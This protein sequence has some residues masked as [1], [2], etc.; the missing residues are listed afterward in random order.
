M[1]TA[2]K[3]IQ[4]LIQIDQQIDKTDGEGLR[5]RWVFGKEL[6][7]RRV[8]KKLPAGLLKKL[9][10]ATGK[11]KTEISY[12]A[13]FAEKY[14]TEQELSNALDNFRS[15]FE[16]TQ[17]LSGKL[18]TEPERKKLPRIMFRK[19]PN[20]HCVEECRSALQKSIRVGDEDLAMYC[21]AEICL[22]EGGED[23]SGYTLAWNAL[24]TTGSED[25][26]LTEPVAQEIR[27]LHQNFLEA[28]KRGQ[29]EGACRLH[30]TRAVL[31]LCRA[32]KNRETDHTTIRWFE[33]HREKM[34]LNLLADQ[35][36][37]LFEDRPKREFP[38]RVYDMHTRRGRGMGR[39]VEHFFAEGAKLA[40]EDGLRDPHR[41][42]AKQIR[43]AAKTAA[44]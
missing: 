15:W 42:D 39:G 7:A 38:D 34:D 6:L 16:V 25:I 5:Q 22:H 11:S 10:G 2:K 23:G 14:A 12:R 33:G 44:A 18:T 19:T 30:L 20:G 32:A 36:S 1:T 27:A 4:N 9:C 41:E 13:Q 35:L 3:D 29:L 28:K 40:N 31:L 24:Q 8:G 37:P 17:H 21:T 26:S 43:L